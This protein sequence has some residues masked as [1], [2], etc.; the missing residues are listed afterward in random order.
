MEKVSKV[1]GKYTKQ[2]GTLYGYYF[3]CPGCKEIHQIP[4]QDPK[5]HWVLDDTSTLEKPTFTPS[6]NHM[7]GVFDD[8]DKPVL[9]K[10]GHQVMRTTC[11]YFITNGQIVYQGDCRHE[12]SGK[13]IDMPEIPDRP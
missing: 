2:D 1:L 11:H 13:T 5:H 6:V 12:F 4:T 3:W 8:N 10:D 9:D 7:E